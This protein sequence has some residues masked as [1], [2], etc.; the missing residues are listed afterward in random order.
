MSEVNV[1]RLVNEFCSL[2]KI[3]SESPNDHEFINHLEG[4]F[5]KLGGEAKKDSYGNLIVKFAA[6]NSKSTTPIAFTAHA[7][8]VSPGT[9]VEPVVEGGRVRSKGDTILGADDKSAI[10]QIMEMIR[11]TEKHPPIE[12]II[13]RCEESGSYGSLNLDYSRVRSKI[14]YVMDMNMPEEIIVGGPTLVAFNVTYKGKSAHA[15]AFP[16]KGI[17]AILAASKAVTMLRLGKLD[18]D[19]SANVGVF[20]GGEVRN[21]VPANA[22]ILAE[23]RCLKHEKALALADEME[24]I[25]RKASDEV[26][27]EVTI[28]REILLKAYFVEEKAPA[29][30]AAVTALKKNG[31]KPVV[32]IIRG[33]TDATTLNAHGIVSVALGVGCREI[34]TCDEYAIIDEMVT[35]TNVM[36]TIVEDLA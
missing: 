31:V 7:D 9:G 30:Q 17:S 14:A 25:F 20:H 11:V 26:G 10:A 6:K 8:T 19:T 35:M 24:K 15:G 28:E 3:P 12:I 23:C 33:G 22:K 27:T 1:D 34:H 5:N 16:E 29:V 13:T 2:V 36:R 21:G 18:E 4:L 32:K